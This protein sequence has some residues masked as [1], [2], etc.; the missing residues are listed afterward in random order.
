MDK[1]EHEQV[2]RKFLRVGDTLTHTRCMGCIEEHLY[3]RNDGSWLC[4]TPT[5]D[6]I[7][8][9]GSKHE[10]NDIAPGNVTHLNRTPIECLEIDVGFK[11]RL[12][13]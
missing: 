2:L 12:P 13:G 10:A 7:R 9:G 8:L 11:D 1:A 4:G 5:K 3:T 6:T